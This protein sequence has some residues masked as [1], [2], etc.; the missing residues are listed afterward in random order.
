[1]KKLTLSFVAAFALCLGLNAGKGYDQ[2]A[3]G[4]QQAPTQNAQQHFE[5]QHDQAQCDQTQ[6]PAPK[7]CPA[8]EAPKDCPQQAPAEQHPPLAKKGKF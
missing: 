6:A 1:M 5:G 4:H 8:Q 2:H 7:D 3:Q